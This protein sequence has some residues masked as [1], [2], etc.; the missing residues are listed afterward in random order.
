MTDGCCIRNAS[1]DK[2]T[3]LA[4]MKVTATDLG[5]QMGRQQLADIGHL[6][7]AMGSPSAGDPSRASS[8][9]RRSL[10]LGRGGCHQSGFP[11]TDAAINPG[12]S[13]GPLIV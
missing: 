9:S 2:A 10:K 7:L 12:N 6:V 8:A 4:V 3:D 1:G 13:G 11:E 5:C